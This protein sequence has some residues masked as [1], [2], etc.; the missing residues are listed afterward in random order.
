MTEDARK[1]PAGRSEPEGWPLKDV[2][3]KYEDIAM[4]FNDLLKLG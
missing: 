1:N 2:W 3:E 4:N